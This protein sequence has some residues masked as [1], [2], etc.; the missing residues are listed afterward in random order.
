[1]RAPAE[2][3]E[4]GITDWERADSAAIDPVGLA[5]SAAIPVASTAE[6]DTNYCLRLLR[7]IRDCVFATLDAGGLPSARVIDVMHTE[8]GRLYFLEPRGKA[9]Y[10]E[11]MANSI[12][13][14]VG[15]TVDY[16]TCRIRGHAVR[17][18]D[19]EQRAL[20][21]WMFRLNPSMNALYPGESRYAC[22]VFFV[23]NG[24]GDYLDLRQSPIVRAAFSLGGDSLRMGRFFEVSDPCAGCG[25]CAKACPQRN[26]SLTADGCYQINQES[27]LH[28][29]LCFEAC[30]HSAI[31]KVDEA[32]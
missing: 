22:E 15:Q 20:V 11:L 30:E 3:A 27:C 17:A 13:A 4:R 8:G 5:R 32:R 16:R 21:D 18:S 19:A 9:F 23:D 7:E 28:C 2:S 12:V 14:I 25:T 6:I 24:S 1:M 10:A 31:A 26:I 29:G